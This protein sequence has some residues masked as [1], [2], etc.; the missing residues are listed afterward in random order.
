MVVISPTARPTTI[1]TLLNVLMKKA[2][3][4][5]YL[6]CFHCFAHPGKNAS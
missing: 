4:L 3:M 2:H 6:K 1:N 5:L